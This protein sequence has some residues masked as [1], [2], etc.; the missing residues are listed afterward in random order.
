M[1]DVQVR[2]QVDSEREKVEVS[3]TWPQLTVLQL[4]RFP[5]AFGVLMTRGRRSPRSCECSQC[6]KQI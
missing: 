4:F 1:E 6:V 2:G 5:Q 3:R